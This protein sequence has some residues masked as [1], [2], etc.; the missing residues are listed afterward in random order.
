M[1]SP[2][3]EESEEG[4]LSFVSQLKAGKGLTLVARCVEGNFIRQPDLAES[5]RTV[6]EFH[7]N[8]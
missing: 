3:D 4:L 5:N 8:L 2:E 1:L 7:R 6:I